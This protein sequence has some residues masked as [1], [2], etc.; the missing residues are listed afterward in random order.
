VSPVDVPPNASRDSTAAERVDS[1]LE[2]P[3]KKA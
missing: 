3:T 2:N 1:S